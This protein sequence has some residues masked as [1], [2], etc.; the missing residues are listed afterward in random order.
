[1]IAPD[2]NADTHVQ[3][4]IAMLDDLLFK[5]PVEKGLV[6]DREKTWR[7]DD[8]ILIMRD[9][10][11]WD[12]RVSIVDLPAFIGKDSVLDQKARLVGRTHKNPAAARMSVISPDELTRHAVGFAEGMRRPAVTFYVRLDNNFNLVS[13]TVRRTA[14]ET[15]KKCDFS[16]LDQQ[17]QKKDPTVKNWFRLAE[18]LK[19]KRMANIADVAHSVLAA[20]GSGDAKAEVLDD[21][22]EIRDGDD[23]VQ[24]IMLFASRIADAYIKD[25]KLP[26]LRISHKT[27]V[28][29]FN[30][31]ID[32]ALFNALS[33]IGKNITDKVDGTVIPCVSVTS[34][35]QKY[36]DLVML[37]MIADHCT[38]GTTAYSQSEL[39]EIETDLRLQSLRKR[40]VAVLMPELHN[41]RSVSGAFRRSA[42]SSKRDNWRYVTPALK[43]SGLAWEVCDARVR[44]EGTTVMRLA[45]IK[46][47]GQVITGIG[48]TGMEAVEDLTP[49]LLKIAKPTSARPARRR[50][51][52]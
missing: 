25:N 17:S 8:G 1:M 41:S 12:L 28:N 14:F 15:L 44:F 35:L 18:G 16:Y 9:E 36:N 24:E 42:G 6:I 47:D 3:D 37:R 11:G 45:G 13:S 29:F 31:N 40:E 10:N 33:K 23:F 4:A 52:V 51:F 50:E 21:L 48:M 46:I 30:Q 5:R 19:R 26:A 38:S 20:N 7:C 2:F 27:A 39:D 32:T 34:P 43:K 49:N 22:S